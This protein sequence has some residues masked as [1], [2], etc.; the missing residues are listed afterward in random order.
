MPGASSWA[1]EP[2]LDGWR[3]LV[4][5]DDGVDVRTRTGRSIT[6]SVPELE[7]LPEHLDGRRAILDGELIAGQGRPDDFYRLGPRLAASRQLA[8]RRW[9][10]RV[11]LTFAVFDLLYEDG[12]DLTG[13]PYDARRARLESLQLNGSAWCTVASYQSDGLELLSACS[14]HDLEGVVAKRLS[15]SYRAGR[16]SRD[17]IKIKTSSWQVHHAPRRHENPGRSAAEGRDKTRV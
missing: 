15:S 13:C 3:V 10:E 6:T 1:F 11:P 7:G 12:T 4:Y 9:R 2:K 16:R 17:W 14:E 8:V 5:L